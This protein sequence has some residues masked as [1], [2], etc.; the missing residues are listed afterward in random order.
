MLV[1][2]RFRVIQEANT[3]NAMGGTL[4][5]VLGINLMYFE[6]EQTFLLKK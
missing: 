1:Q 5:E 2:P 3:E 6:L 4:K